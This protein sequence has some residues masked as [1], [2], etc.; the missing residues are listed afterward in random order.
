MLDRIHDR[1]LGNMI[2]LGGRCCIPDVDSVVAS[3]C[4]RN[5]KSLANICG[6]T[7]QGNVQ[8]IG[9]KF[10]RKETASEDA[11]KIDSILDIL[12]NLVGVFDLSRRPLSKF[13]TKD[14]R[15]QRRPS[16]MLD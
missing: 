6:Q 7:V 11:V 3:E 14:L 2:K 1:F 15:G 13:L 5:P 16:Q 4:A 8:S 9:L 10:R 12:Y